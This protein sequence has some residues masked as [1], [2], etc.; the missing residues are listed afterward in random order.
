[1]GIECCKCSKL[2]DSKKASIYSKNTEVSD[3][4]KAPRESRNNTGIST[5]EIKLRDKSAVGVGVEEP[6]GCWASCFPWAR[7][8]EKEKPTENPKSDDT[9]VLLV[10]QLKDSSSK[11]TSQ[12]LSER[13]PV[14]VELNENVVQCEIGKCDKTEETS[15]DSTVKQVKVRIAQQAKPEMCDE[16]EVAL[17]ESTSNAVK[18]SRT[19]NAKTEECDEKEEILTESTSNTVKASRELKAK[20]EECDEK[21]EVLTES[22]SNTVK[23][24]RELKAK[25]EAYEEKEEVLTESTSNTVKASRELKAKAEACDEKEEV[26]T[27]STSNTVKASRELKAKTE[28]C[29]EK[30][31]VLTE[32]TPNAVKASTEQKAESVSLDLEQRS[33]AVGQTNSID[34][35]MNWHTVHNAKLSKSTMSARDMHRTKKGVCIGYVKASTSK[36]WS[37]HLIEHNIGH[38]LKTSGQKYKGQRVIGA[39][40]S[41]K[42]E[43]EVV[44]NVPPEVEGVQ[45]HRQNGIGIRTR[46]KHGMCIDF[47]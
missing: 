47:D 7:K 13:Y 22:T 45:M 30:E 43:R 36:S 24:S 19:P 9:A 37:R 42:H 14:A 21:E 3:Y 25:A 39:A 32:S 18:D 31:E 28:E 20:T 33:N 12:E 2:Y 17:A 15:V 5:D 29:D 10:G 34:D 23:A 27:E 1:M 41:P 6:L 35:W 38:D 40:I 16:I 11:R 8:K 26:L 44:E 46:N 4:K